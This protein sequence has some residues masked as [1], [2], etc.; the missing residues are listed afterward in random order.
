MR[1]A[2]IAVAG[3]AT[4]CVGLATPASAAP[5]STVAACGAVLDQPGTYQLVTDLTCSQTAIRVA[6]DNVRLLLD[7]HRLSGTGGVFPGVQVGERSAPGPSGVQIVGGTVSGFFVGVEFSNASRGAVTSVTVEA[8]STGVL[9][10]GSGQGLRVADATVDRNIVGIGSTC[11]A[12]T[13]AG[14]RLRGNV[15]AGILLGQG[16][17][18]R[19]VGNHVSGT[20]SSAS[21]A[22]YLSDYTTANTVSGNTVTDNA[23]DGVLVDPGSVGNAFIGNTALRNRIDLAD[24]N[25]RTGGSACANRWTGNRFVTDSEGDGPGAGCIR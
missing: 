2:L 16:S 11:S 1:Q 7:G 4:L 8:G 22:I 23:G 3:A 10:R 17:G 25:T 19:I 12:T 5:I 21:G 9:C 6:A 15:T 13:V 24:L 14:S 20:T 18:S